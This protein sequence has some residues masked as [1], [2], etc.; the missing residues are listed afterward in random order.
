MHLA[1]G[2]SALAAE[3]AGFELGLGMGE[4]GAV[5][6]GDAGSGEAD[7]RIPSDW[8]VCSWRVSS[9]ICSNSWR[10][11]VICSRCKLPNICAIISS[12][13]W[14]CSNICCCIWENCETRGISRAS[15]PFVGTGSSTGAVLWAGEFSPVFLCS[16]APLGNED[17]SP[18]EVLFPFTL[19]VNARVSLTGCT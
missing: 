12:V 13:C 15:T 18:P 1:E 10:M 9:R 6:C 3:S 19:G 2:V 17:K 4:L 14:N 7:S 11:I 8:S 5:A 16:E